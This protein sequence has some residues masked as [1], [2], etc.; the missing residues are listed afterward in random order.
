MDTLMQWMDKTFVPA[1]Y[2]VQ[3]YNGASLSLQDKFYISDLTN[4][5]LGLVRFRQ[6]RMPKG[7]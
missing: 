1:F 7:N 4:I 3:E 5:R 6:V 2:P